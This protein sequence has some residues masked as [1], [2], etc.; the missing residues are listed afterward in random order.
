MAKLAVAQGD[1]NWLV[2]LGQK[3]PTDV[4][5]FASLFGKLTYLISVCLTR[6]TAAEVVSINI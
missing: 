2:P 4:S 5:Y 3:M 6:N 1:I